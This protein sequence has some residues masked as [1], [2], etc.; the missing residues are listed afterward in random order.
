MTTVAK[1]K[2]GSYKGF[3]SKAQWLMAMGVGDASAVR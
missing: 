2:G 3:K 1:R